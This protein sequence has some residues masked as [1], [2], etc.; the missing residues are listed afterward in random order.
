MNVMSQ[1]GFE[2]ALSLAGMQVR[3]GN[4]IEVPWSN[5]AEGESVGNVAWAGR[6]MGIF[7]VDWAD[8]KIVE[9]ETLARKDVSYVALSSIRTQPGR[10]SPSAIIISTRRA[11]I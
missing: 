2:E 8:S 3:G 9:L 4:L 5:V 1:V 10:T 11:E 7:V 6:D